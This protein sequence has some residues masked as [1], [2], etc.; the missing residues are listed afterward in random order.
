MDLIFWLLAGHFIGDFAFQPRWMAEGKKTS[1]EITAYHAATYASYMLIVSA[2]GGFRLS[3]AELGIF[4]FS[5]LFIDPL[6]AR[7]GIIREIWVDQIL[8]F[9]VILLVVLS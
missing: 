9:I 8:H 7:F 2:I 3:T 1:W 4:F 6:K 5:H